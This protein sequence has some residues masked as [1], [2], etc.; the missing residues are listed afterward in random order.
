V[1]VSVEDKDGGFVEVG[2]HFLHG[3]KG[4]WLR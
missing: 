3:V 4:W 1:P 2:G